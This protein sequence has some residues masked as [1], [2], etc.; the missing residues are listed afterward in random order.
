MAE[1][2]YVPISSI[3]SARILI[4]GTHWMMATVDKK[5]KKFSSRTSNYLNVGRH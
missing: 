2:N 5:F 1:F 3:L 4:A